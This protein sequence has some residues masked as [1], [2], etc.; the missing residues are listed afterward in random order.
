MIQQ[1]IMDLLVLNTVNFQLIQRH[2]YLILY[3]KLLI[4]LLIQMEMKVEYKNVV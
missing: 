2:L 1:E 4:L 3:T